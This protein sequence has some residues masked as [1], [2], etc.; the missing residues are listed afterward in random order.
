MLK[1][2]VCTYFSSKCYGKKSSEGPHQLFSTMCQI[3]TGKHCG[4]TAGPNLGV[5]SQH[6]IFYLLNDSK[7]ELHRL[8]SLDK[9]HALLCQEIDICS[10]IIGWGV[11]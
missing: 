4:C 2:Y 9:G 6:W 3:G 7:V 5:K 8:Y 10:S 1:I 11:I